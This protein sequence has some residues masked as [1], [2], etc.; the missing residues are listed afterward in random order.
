MLDDI[1]DNLCCK[2]TTSVSVSLAIMC[3]ILDKFRINDGKIKLTLGSIMSWLIVTG[4]AISMCLG[5]LFGFG[6]LGQNFYAAVL[7]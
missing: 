2:K 4:L 6:L 5:T 1:Y 3:E 7:V